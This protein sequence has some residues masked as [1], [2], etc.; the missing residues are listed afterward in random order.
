MDL[1]K[2]IWSVESMPM[3][4][5]GHLGSFSG[6]AGK[7]FGGMSFW[8]NTWPNDEGQTKTSALDLQPIT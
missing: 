2:S 3:F 6:R 8:T 4:P 7:T 5:K 1:G